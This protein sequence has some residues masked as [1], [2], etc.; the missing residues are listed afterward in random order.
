MKRR[1][2]LRMSEVEVV[3]E[4]DEVSVEVDVAEVRRKETR[5]ELSP[6]SKTGEAEVEEAEAVV[7]EVVGRINLMLNVTSVASMAITRRTATRTDVITVAELVTSR[8]IVEMRRGQMG[9]QI[10]FQKK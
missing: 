3:A 10:M 1:S 7:V 6:V 8:K 2:T 5:K 4:L 9:P